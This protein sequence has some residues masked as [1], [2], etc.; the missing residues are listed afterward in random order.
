MGFILYLNS[1]INS[2]ADSHAAND[3]YVSFKKMLQCGEERLL[4]RLKNGVGFLGGE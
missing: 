3:Q 2:K 1:E 4:T